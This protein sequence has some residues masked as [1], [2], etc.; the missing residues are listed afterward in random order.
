MED[1]P[2]IQF[3]RAERSEPKTS[4]NDALVITALLANNEVECIFMDFESSVHILFGK[5]YDQMQLGEI[6][7][8]KLNTFPYGFTGEVVHP[9]GMISLPLMLGTWNAQST[10]MLK[11]LVVDVLSAYNVIFGSPNLNVF[12]AVIST[13]HMK[14]KFSTPKEK[15]KETPS[16]REMLYRGCAQR[17]EETSNK[18]PKGAPSS[19]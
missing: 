14:I 1:A 7:L 13:Y 8:K 10:C 11:L 16:N 19:K 18:N 4:H 3:G 5:A 9:R 6:P 12:Q 2:L 15:F 17:T